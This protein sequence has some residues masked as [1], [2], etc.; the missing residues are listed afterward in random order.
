MYFF[1]IWA[2]LIIVIN[3]EGVR[4]TQ[5][6]ANRRCQR[7]L[8]TARTINLDKNITKLAMIISIFLTANQREINV[9]VDNRIQIL[10]DLVRRI[11]LLN[12]KSNPKYTHGT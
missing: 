6:P 8:A 4:V 3:I 1:Q 7:P 11:R 2:N 10:H 12:K 5:W 9:L